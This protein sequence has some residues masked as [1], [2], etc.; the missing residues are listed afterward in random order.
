MEERENI[1]PSTNKTVIIISVVAVLLL[2]AIS[3]LVYQNT[4]LEDEKIQKEA[5]L[6]NAFLQLDSAVFS[7]KLVVVCIVFYSCRLPPILGSSHC[8]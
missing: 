2:A 7:G 8:A 1:K 5:E 4:K 6:D 3:F